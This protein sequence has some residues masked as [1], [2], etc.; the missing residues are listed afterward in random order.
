M[1]SRS[2]PLLKLATITCRHY[3]GHARKLFRM[4]NFLWVGA[5]LM[6]DRHYTDVAMDN[7][8]PP[9]GRHPYYI[10]TPQYNRQS[11]GIRALHLLTHWLNRVGQSAFLAI[12]AG[13]EKL[14]INP[15]LIA[16]E[17]TP[18]IIQYHFDRKITPIVLYPEV[19]SD[20]PL[21]APV[22]VRY[23]ANFPGLLGGDRA[24]N[25][26]ELNFGYSEVL[27]QAAGVPGSV[28]HI[29]MVDT[30]IFHR[31]VSVP[32]TQTCYY[33]AKFKTMH[34]GKTFG[35]PD[36]CV[37]I[38]RFSPQE[39]SQHE[40]AELFRRSTL[41]YCFENTAL[42]LEAALCGCPTVLMPNAFFTKPISSIEFG[43]DGMAWGDSPTEIERARRTV[44]RVAETY[45]AT[46]KQF[47]AQLQTFIERT[48]ERARRT[49]YQTIIHHEPFLSPLVATSL[50]AEIVEPSDL[51]GQ[52]QSESSVPVGTTTFS[53]SDLPG[54]LRAVG[55]VGVLFRLWRAIQKGR[56]GIKLVLYRDP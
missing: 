9:T 21:R 34:G 14:P 13:D 2:G 42:S 15:E 51:I 26:E 49:R 1:T 44:G 40:I 6:P 30:Q 52:D 12:Y 53:L 45:R 38:L 37:E 47:F 18:E 10:A 4:E 48:Q 46:C 54:A 23:F 50:Q 19:V 33:A 55:F 43:L 27:A 11:G 41:F 7:L 32:R 29:P 25:P 8:F 17:L 39:Q 56:I 5:F 16:P 22:V 28:L 36:G 35:L 3:I 24:F 31:G 20:N